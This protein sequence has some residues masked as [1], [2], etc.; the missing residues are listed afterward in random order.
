MARRRARAVVTDSSTWGLG[1]DFEVGA[2]LPLQPSQSD[3]VYPAN[4]SVR[5]GRILISGGRPGAGVQRGA[6]RS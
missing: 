4:S 5:N 2:K 1:P 3:S 6:S